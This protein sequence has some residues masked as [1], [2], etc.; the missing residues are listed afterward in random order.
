MALEFIRTGNCFYFNLSISFF[1][2]ETIFFIWLN[3][4]VP[5]VTNLYP[6]IHLI[7]PSTIF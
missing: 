3:P 2:T 5:G 1:E 7:L 6:Q 4:L